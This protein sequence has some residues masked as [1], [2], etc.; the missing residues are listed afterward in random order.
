MHD[1]KYI[2]FHSCLFMCFLQFYS[3]SWILEYLCKSTLML[4]LS[5]EDLSCYPSNKTKHVSSILYHFFRHHN[6]LKHSLTIL[7][8]ICHVIL[9]LEL[10]QSN[11]VHVSQSIS[12]MV[13]FELSW[14]SLLWSKWVLKGIISYLVLK[15]LNLCGQTEFS[16]IIGFPQAELGGSIKENT[17]VHYFTN[18]S[19]DHVKVIDVI[20]SSIYPCHYV[21]CCFLLCT[22]LKLMSQSSLSESI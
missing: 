6:N 14:I 1:I 10:K 19:I 5:Y 3:L 17:V 2:A 8:D 7:F 12:L 4:M 20:S 21:I 11:H 18:S 13:F 22:S 16:N 9:H 15:H